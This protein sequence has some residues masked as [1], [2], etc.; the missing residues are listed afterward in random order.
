MRYIFV[1][2]TIISAEKGCTMKIFV[3]LLFALLLIAVSVACTAN[4]TQS[5]INVS[6]AATLTDVIKEVNS[7]YMKQKPGLK[8]TT[9][10]TSSGT[11]Q[12]QIENGAP[13]DVFISG[14][15]LQMD[16]L[17]KKG[18]I[19]SETR[20]DLL[21]N[22][23]VLI[24]PNSSSLSI[25]SFSGL[26]DSSIKV[27]AIGDPKSV[28]AGMYAQKALEDAGLYDKLKPKFVLASDV[29]QVLTYVEGG[30][31]DAG[32]VYAT[33]AKISARVKVVAVAPADINA[34]ITY[35]VAVIKASKNQVAAIEYENFLTG[36][37]ALGIFTK[38]GFKLIK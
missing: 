34:Q 16:N 19:L 5:S 17:E 28:T 21:S 36:A 22:E 9:N 3:C 2:I 4:Q 14:A 30:N 7:V 8:I 20:K 37:E 24:V 12:S 35:P 11:I 1:D 29:R 23:I 25:G 6:A 15:A 26:A 31:A 18:L 33:D 10:F 32:F 38:F 27:I 13:V